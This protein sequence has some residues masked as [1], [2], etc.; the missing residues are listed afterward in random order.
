M[1]GVQGA[2]VAPAARILP[3]RVLDAA[4]S[5]T[6]ASVARGI[7]WATDHGATVMNM[8]LGSPQDSATVHDA[9]KR[10]K[11]AGITI[12]VAAGNEGSTRVGYP[13]MYPE[14]ITVGAT[15]Q[16]DHRPAWSN[17]GATYVNVGAPG[18]DTLAT[19]VGG[20]A[21]YMSGTSMAAPLVAGVAALLRSVGVAPSAILTVLQRTADPCIGC[22]FGG[23]RVDAGAAVASVPVTAPTATARPPTTVPPTV[24]P[25]AVPGVA[26][27]TAGAVYQLPRGCWRIQEVAC[28]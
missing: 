20:G 11:A 24:A 27:P 18:V 7:V 14:V 10:A 1:N 13:A 3:V 2:G 22:Q 16:S 21:G 26:T 25:T 23:G 17:Y 12:V 9:V 6:M 19:T 28:P 15:D 4:G 8:S 5:G